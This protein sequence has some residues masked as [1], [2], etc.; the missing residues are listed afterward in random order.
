MPV[1]VYP[2]VIA[3]I[4]LYFIIADAWDR[5]NYTSVFLALNFGVCTW[6]AAKYLY[7]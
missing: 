3:V 5:R 2:S 7:S 1:I 6:S 4:T